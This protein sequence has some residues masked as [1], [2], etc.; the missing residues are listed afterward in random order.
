[1]NK[2]TKG[3]FSMVLA[4]A[5]TFS[6]TNA[7]LSDQSSKRVVKEE[8]FTIS[9]DQKKVDEFKRKTVNDQTPT[10]NGGDEH[11]NAPIQEALNNNESDVAIAA[12]P[13]DTKRNA[14]VTTTIP[15]ISNTP[16]TTSPAAPMTPDTSETAPTVTT[17]PE[18]S[19]TN[20]PSA[21]KW[22]TNNGQEVSQ[23]AKE[24]A[25]SHQDNKE[26][27]GKKM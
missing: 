10:T 5:V 27:N 15:A 12:I 26:N 25:A 24:K 2:L 3:A 20:T 14:V 11:N 16:T 9:G 17:T 18:T 21:P 1:M 4:G 7:L 13:Q 8:A 19:G 22:P 6:V 23:A